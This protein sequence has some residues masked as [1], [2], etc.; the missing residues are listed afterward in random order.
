MTV[1][2]PII[3]IRKWYIMDFT[4]DGKSDPCLRSVYF[5]EYWEPGE[6]L[7]SK[8]YDSSYASGIS[9]E[10]KKL[11]S[12]TLP[13]ME[14]YA[15]LSAWKSLPLDAKDAGNG[16][17]NCW[18]EVYLWGAIVEHELGY[19]AEF[20]YPKCLFVNQLWEELPL[21]Y[22]GKTALSKF[23][24]LAKKYDCELKLICESKLS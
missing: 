15:G 1:K 11:L 18:G 6:V 22:Q 19:R 16:W 4:Q 14:N 20:A 17:G 24:Y 9:K 8:H 13:T 2:E 23:E 21:K 7:A 5:Q 3:G 12:Y 10:S